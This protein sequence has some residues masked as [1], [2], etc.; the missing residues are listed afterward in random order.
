MVADIELE[1]NAIGIG[2]EMSNQQSVKQDLPL[3]NTKLECFGKTAGYLQ[4]RIFTFL[5]CT[6]PSL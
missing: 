1:T 6:A 5:Q 3:H 4:L 2:H